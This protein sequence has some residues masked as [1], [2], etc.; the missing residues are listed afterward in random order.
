MRVD[1]RGHNVRSSDDEADS[2]AGSGPPVATYD[3]IA[4][5]LTD[6]FYNFWG[7]PRGPHYG[8]ETGDTVTVNITRLAP[9][10]QQLARW[11]LEAWTNV[12]GIEFQFVSVTADIFFTDWSGDYATGAWGRVNVPASALTQHGTALDARPFYAYVHEIGH[13]LGLGH[14]GDY[15]GADQEAADVTYADAK[16]LNDSTQASVMSYIDQDENPY[17]D[18]SHAQPVTPMIADIIAIQNLYGVP[19]A[20]NAGDTV[21]GYGSNVGGY[22]G[23]LFAAMSGEEPD[24]DFYGG[25]PV[26]LTIYDTDGEDTLD[27]RWDADDQRVDLRPEGI[28]DVLG[29]TGNWVIARDTVIENFVAGSGHDEVTG[30]DAANRL[31]GR[32]GNDTLA[33]ASGDDRLDGGDGNDRLTGG[34]GADVLDGGDGRDVLRYD[35]SDAGVAVDLSAG[36]ASGGHAEGDTFENVEAVHGSRHADTLTGGDGNDWLIG[37]EGDDLLTGGRGNDVL[38]GGPG[39]DTMDGGEGHDRLWYHGSDAGVAVDLSA[40]TASGGHAEGDTFEN[41]EEIVGSRHADT[42]TGGGGNDWLIGREGDDVLG[43]GAGNDV[44]VGGAGADTM[45]GGEGHDRLWYHGSDAGV[46]V[47][48]SA[49]TASGGHAEGDTFENV[50]GIGGSE[51]ADTLTGG[52]GDDWL[53]GRGGDDRLTGGAGADAL[54]GGAGTDTLSYAGSNTGVAVDLSA[55]TGSGGHAEGDT[56]R[57]IEHLEGSAHPDTLTGGGGNDWLT[58]GPGADALDGGDG[59]D[60][61]RYDGSNAAVAVDLSA[62]TGSGGHA[63]GDTFENVEA[64]VGSAYADTLTG[65][66]GNDRFAGGAGA[67]SMDGGDGED[68]LCY[69]ASDAAV[70][71]YLSTGTASG[72]H[73]GGDTFRNV[74]AVRGSP[75]ADRLWGG[76]GND[77]LDGGNGNDRLAGESGDDV[78]TGGAGDDG[79]IGGAGADRMDGGDGNDDL[80]YDESDAGVAV[81]LSAG[82]GSGGHADGDTFENVE[83]VYGSQH[84]D[85]LTGGDGDDWL[86]GEGGD[87]ALTGGAGNDLLTGGA[88]ADQMDGG[89]GNDDLRYGESDAGV[90]VDLSAGT[91]SG[92]HAEGDT[93]E[94][95]EGVYGSQ[96][97]DTLTGGDGD[98]W[99]SGAAGADRLD[100]A[101]GAD[102]LYGGAGDDR[103][104]GGARTDWLRG[105]A[106][107][108]TLEGGDG[109]DWLYSD[110][111][112]DRLYGGAGNDTLAGDDGD[113]TLDGGEGSDWLSGE[114]GADRLYGGADSDRLYGGAGDDTLEGGEGHD[115]LYGD[116]GAD[117]LYGGADSDRLYGGAGDDRLDGGAHTDWLRGGA[118]DDTFVFDAGTPNA[119][120]VIRDFAD[121]PSP[122]GEQD[123]IELLGDLTFASLVFAASGNDVVITTR[124]ETGNVH[125]TLQNYLVDHEMGDLTAE[126]F[127]FG[128]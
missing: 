76:D 53:G 66:G 38:V 55:G 94:N 63:E 89:D 51:H 124:T 71:V 91:G 83:A 70:T 74:E 65:G 54:D 87:D 115:W 52:N 18:A 90:A 13:A 33:G 61:L 114:A 96:H 73:A 82:T 75:H 113:D 100:G 45:D 111:G 127:L 7:G 59:I 47:D 37:A 78:L 34:P 25:G 28:S 110:D 49:G 43:G 125:I 69:A 99:L 20:I 58:G 122:T 41:V 29:L 15:P 105:G 21:Y 2:E 98:D 97:A 32:A 112:D 79:L 36:T 19:A 46:A 35:Q 60:V 108:D 56:F 106:G 81:D 6:G 26:A 62:G 44:L 86:Y 126:D 16:F 103:L 42:L 3:E 48:L 119:A 92:G 22:L 40:E 39:A 64:V 30:N 4:S 128:T 14:A 118:G 9:E 12:T 50:E 117:R 104:D 116:D 5:Q 101:A 109:D 77:T 67:D 23:Q 80:R 10:G 85:T 8:A 1:P 57:G 27:L 120:D 24:P 68:W 11:A 72:G 93:F 95:I 88:G 84:A 17:I 121:D 31:E 102:R 107:D 123:V